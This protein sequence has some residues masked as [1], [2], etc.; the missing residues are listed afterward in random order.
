VDFQKSLSSTSR[1]PYALSVTQ[2]TALK[3]Y[4]QKSVACLCAVRKRV[5]SCPSHKAHGAALIWSPFPEPWARHQLTLWDHGYGTSVLRGVPVYSPAFASTHCAYAWRD[6]QAELTW[7]A[8]YVPWWF[9]RLQLVIHPSTNRAWHIVTS[10][11]TRVD[12]HYAETPSVLL[13]DNLQSCCNWICMHAVLRISVDIHVQRHSSVTSPM[14]PTPAGPSSLVI[15]VTVS[16]EIDFSSLLFFFFFWY[17]AVLTLPSLGRR[18]STTKNSDHCCKTSSKQPS[19]GIMS[20][21]VYPHLNVPLNRLIF[22]GFFVFPSF[23]DYVSLNQY[24]VYYCLCHWFI[25]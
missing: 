1:R 11:V 17:S 2:P 8:G 6:G 16:T 4:E 13:S 7:V 24:G 20:C 14:T 12:Y 22:P 5:K 19:M 21:L 18:Q 10:F 9:T 15:Q 3:H 23:Y 25:V